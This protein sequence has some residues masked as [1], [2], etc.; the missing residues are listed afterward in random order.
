MI[1]E[2]EQNGEPNTPRFAFRLD[3]LHFL[4]VVIEVHLG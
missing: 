4:G 1:E 2:E 3:V